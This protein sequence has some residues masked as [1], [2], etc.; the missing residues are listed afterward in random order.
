MIKTVG[1]NQK[2]DNY[3]YFV[4]VKMGKTQ[5]KSANN[6]DAQVTVIQNQELHS[7]EHEQQSLMLWLILVVVIMQLVIKLY[8]MYKNREKKIALKAARSIA[9]INVV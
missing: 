2:I 1:D 8:Q 3:T 7:E 5:S 4:L 6:G 9:A